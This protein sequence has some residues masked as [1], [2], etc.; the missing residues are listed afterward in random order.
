MS[1]YRQSIS[2]WCLVPQLMSP[3]QLVRAA[4]QAGYAAVE[5]LPEMY[6][7][8]AREHGLAI[9]SIN[10]HGSI[11]DGLNDRTNHRRIVQELEE[12]LVKAKEWGIANL[13]CFSGS[14]RAL[15]DA[16]G[17]EVT[18]EGLAQVARRAEEAGVTLVLEVLNSK[19]DHPDY[20]ADH[21][22]WAV[23]VCRRVGS[24]AVKVLYDIYHMQIMEGDIIRTIQSVHPWIGHYHT[25]GN[26]GRA[27]LDD[28]QELNYP[29]IFRAIAQTGY[30]GYIGHEFIPRHDP[31]AG[32]NAAFTLAN[33]V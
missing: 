13:I 7:P 3:D 24:P 8:L 20:Q 2:W 27:E 28:S 10:G 22:A 31:V 30:T 29:P 6:W 33:L 25:G 18:A 15:D 32:L 26:P 19:V 17:I 16:T 12:N 9:A 4:A 14:R 1:A 23:E 21:T 5:L 11:V